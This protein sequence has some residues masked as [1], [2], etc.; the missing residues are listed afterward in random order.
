MSMFTKKIKHTATN[1]VMTIR[2]VVANITEFSDSTRNSI[3]S[4]VAGHWDLCYIHGE[5]CLY[6]QLNIYSTRARW[7][8]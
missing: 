2:A 3:T 8:K 1:N 6:P 5:I 7:M 4:F